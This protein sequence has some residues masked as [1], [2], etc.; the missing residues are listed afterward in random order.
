MTLCTRA[1]DGARWADGSFWT[2]ASAEAQQTAAGKGEMLRRERETSQR[3]VV[4]DA[5]Y[6]RHPVGRGIGDLLC[7]SSVTVV[8]F[9]PYKQTKRS[10][11][12]E[13]QSWVVK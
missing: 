3:A 7:D 11:P 1:P 4:P 12:K 10:F 13:R 5:N 9:F 2:V 8:C 6:H